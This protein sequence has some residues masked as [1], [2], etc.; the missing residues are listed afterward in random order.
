[1]NPSDK[2]KYI[3]SKPFDVQDY[4]KMIDAYFFGNFIKDSYRLNFIER[5]S[6]LKAIRIKDGLIE[7]N[8]KK[9]DENNVFDIL[10]P[11]LLQILIDVYTKG[12][13]FGFK[14]IECLRKELFEDSRNIPYDLEEIDIPDEVVKK[15]KEL[16]DIN[17]IEKTMNNN[18]MKMYP[19]KLN[20]CYMD[21]LLS[22]IFLANSGFFVT[23]ILK[24]RI[25]VQQYGRAICSLNSPI[26]DVKNYASE[27][28]ELISALFFDEERKK[29]SCLLIQKL[30]QCNTNI[31]LGRFINVA[32]AYDLL[33]DLFPSLKITYRRAEEDKIYIR[34]QAM[35]DMTDLP[36]MNSYVVSRPPV[37]V[38]NNGGLGRIDQQLYEEHLKK[39]TQNLDDVQEYATGLVDWTEKGFEFEILN[40]EYA[41]VGAVLHVG[42]N[43]YTSVFMVDDLEEGW[44]H[45]DDSKGSEAQKIEKHHINV[46]F[47]DTPNVQPAMFFYVKKNYVR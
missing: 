9:F 1:M 26:T 17:Q 8:P 22:I 35:F 33:C 31:R 7:Y 6:L 23:K 3:L 36:Y 47:K 39:T 20:S 16:T 29:H 28:Q 14:E 24:Q 46:I 15:I 38:F 25:S 13:T 41:L 45:Y 34:E 42:L 27:V 44:Y 18:S 21:S 32:E 11:I 19:N 30:A 2:R 43:H 37:L 5:P 40:G 4:A 10:E 12:K